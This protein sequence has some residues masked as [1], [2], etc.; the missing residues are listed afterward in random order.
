MRRFFKSKTFWTVVVVVAA[1]VAI[2]VYGKISGTKTYAD[3]YK[4]FNFSTLVGEGRTDTY[5][6][7][8]AQYPETYPEA[9]VS[10]PL[11]Q[12]SV[13]E[14]KDYEF[15]AAGG[16]DK[17]L[18]VKENGHV[19]IKA[20]VPVAGFYNIDLSYY[21][22]QDPERARGIEM[23]FKLTIND[24]IPFN[25]ADAI[26]LPRVWQDKPWV[27]ENGNVTAK[28]YDNQGNEIR[29]GQIELPRWEETSIS[30]KL[31]YIT[32]PYCF[33]FEEG[34]NTI[35]LDSEQEALVLRSLVL[36]AV[37]NPPKYADYISGQ[38]LSSA[39]TD[40]KQRVEGE[41]S[42]ARSSQSLYSTY[43]RSSAGT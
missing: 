8:V 18:V 10:V 19:V 37:K 16:E 35:R 5:A 41:D 36:S 33:Y 7:Y 34:K 43:D 3:K 39:K 42:T 22:D 11:E 26:T 38:D 12:A 31:G 32:E 27:D 9:D 13:V 30:D 28:R 20:D 17:V 4:G 25:G 21:P 15:G 2:V 29:P 14:G 1:I 23:E 24:K 6:A 40:W